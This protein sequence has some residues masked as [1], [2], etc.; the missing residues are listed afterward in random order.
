MRGTEQ[1]VD[2]GQSTSFTGTGPLRWRVGAGWLVLG[3]GGS[4]RA[5]ETGD[6]DAAALGWAD[7]DRPVAVVPT[8]GMAT[9]EAEA[10]LEY[11]ADLGGPNGYVVPIFDATGAQWQ[12]NCHLLAEAGLIYLADGPDTL[13]LVRALR[14]SPALEGTARAFEAGAVLLGMGAGAAVLGDWVGD[15]GEQRV[16]PG[17][18]WLPN[19]IVT[20][21]FK[22]I[23]QTRQLRRLL[24]LKPNCLGLGVPERTALGLG[25]GGVVE[26]VGP[27]QVTVVVSGLEV[28]G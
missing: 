12:E 19:I 22:G 15:Q 4:W 1:E 18:G 5:N 2:L 26:N 27:G 16:E 17:L 11:Y 28:E 13:G 23:E 20:P 14:A 10:L 21:G 6:V 8:A 25:P 7:L 9:D 24:E 3:G